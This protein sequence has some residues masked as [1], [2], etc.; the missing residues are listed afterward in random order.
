MTAVQQIRAEIV[1]T[2]RHLTRLERALEIVTGKRGIDGAPAAGESGKPKAKPR[3]VKPATPSTRRAKPGERQAQLDKL[4]SD[5]KPRT[6]REVAKEL[7]I[8]AHEPLYRMMDR[9]DY[10]YR[11]EQRDGHSVRVFRR[12]VRENVI[13][14]GEGVH[15]GRIA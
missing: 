8:T 15:A 10:S 2:K 6:T 1:E 12:H 4:M 13:V 9:S 14:P 11:T 5:G 3:L 7:G